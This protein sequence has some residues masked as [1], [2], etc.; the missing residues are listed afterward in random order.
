MRIAI[1]GATGHI[2]RCLALT[3]AGRHDVTLF[4]RRPDDAAAFAQRRGL[5]VDAHPFERFASARFDLVLNAVGYGDAGRIFQADSAIVDVT[6]HFDRM[7][8][9]ALARHPDTAYVF[10]S[11]GAVHGPEYRSAGDAGDVPRRPTDPD[12]PGHFYRLA[13]YEAEA[14]HRARPHLRIADVRIFGFVSHELPLDSE[15]LLAQIFRALYRG[16]VFATTPRE[17]PRDYVTGDDL[18][19]LVD[20]WMACGYP[21]GAYDLLSAAPTSKLRVLDALER[22][23]GLMY[24]VQGARQAAVPLPQRLSQHRG[25][26][27]LRYVPARSSL[28]LVLDVAAGFTTARRS[29]AEALGAAWA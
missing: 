16:E 10:L 7:C 1:L 17:S 3:Y 12:E 14:R 4:A 18:V 29:S 15:L 26:E 5:A 13:K 19:R 27:A 9:D 23:L 2:G 8:I 21:G 28:D 6:E 20:L 11:S 25:A 24:R 22:R